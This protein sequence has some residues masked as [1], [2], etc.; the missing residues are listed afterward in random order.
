MSAESINST[1]NSDPIPAFYLTPLEKS[2]SDKFLGYVVE[3]TA[4]YNVDEPDRPRLNGKQLD[5]ELYSKLSNQDPKDYIREI[6][7]FIVKNAESSIETEISVSIHG[8]AT[9]K[10]DARQRYESI[11]DFTKKNER[12]LK[13]NRHIF[14]GY[15]WPSEAP[16]EKQAWTKALESLPTVMIGS[17]INFFVLG[18]SA[19]L[20]TLEILPKSF[21][22]LW[23]SIFQA[24]YS[25]SY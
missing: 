13:A 7:E 24:V 2:E 15:V 22:R 20:L 17:F 6:A 25:Q 14:L 8:Y 12:V 5:N 3:S 9:S 23:S 21:I 4:P 16:F 18:L 10:S 1:K 11:G 19:F